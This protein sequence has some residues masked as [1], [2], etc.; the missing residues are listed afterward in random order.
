ME[1]AIQRRCGTATL[2][3]HTC[4]R[5]LSRGTS[6]SRTCYGIATGQGPGLKHVQMNSAIL[7]RCGAAT[8]YPNV[9]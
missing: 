7:F 2:R 1:S 4:T 3:P 9:H 8:L 5:A 6:W